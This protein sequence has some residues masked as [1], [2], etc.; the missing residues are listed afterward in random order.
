[1]ALGQMQLATKKTTARK[2]R[3]ARAIRWL[4]DNLTEELL[5]TWL[6]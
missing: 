5:L 6:V 1:M 2:G 3:D 4:I